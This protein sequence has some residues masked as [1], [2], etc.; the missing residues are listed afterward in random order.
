MRP[1]A[2]A[3]AS[4]DDRLSFALQRANARSS[5]DLE[6]ACDTADMD[7]AR[8]LTA[9]LADLLRREHAVL[10]EFLLAL[11]DFDR[12]RLWVELGHS[13]LF[14]FLHRELRLSKGAAYYRKTAAEL[15]QKVPAVIEPLRDGR[16]CLTS[17]I[18]ASKVV[19]AE[20][21]ETL[22]P[23]F[24]HLSK[25]EAMG[26]AAELDPH[27]SPP[28]RTVVTSVAAA[29]AR[30]VA[31]ASSC[32]AASLPVAS[33]GR[34]ERP[35]SEGPVSDPGW[36]DE[37]IAAAAGPP[38][39]RGS[40]CRPEVEPLGAQAHR[41]H[42]TVSGRFLQKL[43][44][45]KS[46]LS[47]S[48][49][50]ATPEEILEAAL[51]LLLAQAAKRKGVVENPRSPSPRPTKADHVP[52]HVKRAVWTRDG[53]RCQW[54]LDSGGICGSTLR[55]EFDH[56]VPRARGGVADVDGLRVL[57]RFHNDLAAR[58]A[59]ADEWMDRFTAGSKRSP[60]QP[61]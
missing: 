11:A 35:E 21:W 57:C 9:L 38:T 59:Y 28:S 3:K 8:A 53:G 16:L 41:L 23:R 22:L 4:R 60:R 39:S 61:A 37:P 46:A 33:A 55:L 17:I 12:R 5:G 42:V 48:R 52:A 18:E 50:G 32:P 47:H 29:P 19:T 6:I 1:V 54:P 13:S 15:I 25:R 44:A 56:V 34:Q 20:N 14:Y 30:Q 45:A 43:E 27:P 31:A 49:P 40:P 24:F 7:T 10:A 58:K 26:L 51:D 36:P 2:Q